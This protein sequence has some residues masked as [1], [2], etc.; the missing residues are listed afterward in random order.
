MTTL[1]VKRQHAPFLGSIRARLMGI[2][3]LFGVAL[4]AIVAALAWLAARDIYAGRQDELR[5]V[6]EV[7]SQGCPTTI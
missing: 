6:V 7:A 4:I 3:A 5:T 1:L 2:I